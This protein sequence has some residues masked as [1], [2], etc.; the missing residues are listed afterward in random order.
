[1]LLHTCRAVIVSLACSLLAASC[2]SPGPETEGTGGGAPTLET[3]DD[4]DFG[5]DPDVGGSIGSVP[6]EPNWSWSPPSCA[7]SDGDSAGDQDPDPGTSSDRGGA[8]AGGYAPGNRVHAPCGRP[9]AT[10]EEKCDRDFEVESGNCSRRLS[11]AERRRCQGKVLEEYASC[12]EDCAKEAKKKTCL[13]MYVDCTDRKYPPCNK[14]FGKTH[15]ILCY[16][17]MHDCENNDR[18]YK[19][20]Q[21]TECGF[22]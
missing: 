4:S 14:R 11:A 19:F 3:K 10:C 20:K 17:C 16:Y 5:S 13:D 18:R 8:L 22:E 6:S 21:C 1:M 12:R 15:R 2:G 9:P 7:A